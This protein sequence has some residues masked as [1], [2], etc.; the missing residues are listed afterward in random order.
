M[1]LRK[2]SL[3]YSFS[4][5]VAGAAI[6]SVLALFTTFSFLL[7][8]Q[9][10][11][12][13]V[14]KAVS[15]GYVIDAYVSNEI[16]RLGLLGATLKQNHHILNALRAARAVGG[17]PASASTTALK[18]ALGDI[19]DT[20]DVSTLTISNAAGESLFQFGEA[21]STVVDEMGGLAAVT[22]DRT[23]VEKVGGANAMI[24]TVTVLENGVRIGRITLGVKLDDRFAARIANDTFAAVTLVSQ[25]GSIATSVQAGLDFEKI[26]QHVGEAQRTRQTVQVHD[27]DTR[28]SQVF[29]ATQI[30]DQPYGVVVGVQSETALATLTRARAAA[31]WIAVAVLLLALI[32]GGGYVYRALRPLLTLQQRAEKVMSGHFGQALPEVPGDE[33]EQLVGQ[34]NW[35]IETLLAHAVELEHAKE[36]ALIASQAKSS[37]LASMS[38]EIRTPMN[39]VIGM[40][41]LLADTELDTQ[42]QDYVETIRSSG[43]SLLR[44]INDI[45][46]FSKIESGKMALE[47]HPFELA[48]CVEEV[49]G[50]VA[51]SAQKKK[52][53]L[54]YMVENDVPAWLN[55]DVTRVR[56]VLVNLIGNSVKFTDS[57]EVVVNIS[58]RE[59]EPGKL[60]I[61]FAIKD[62]GIGIP[63]EK[64]AV[65]FQPFYQVDASTSRKYGGSGLGLAI[66]ARLVKLMGG[67][68]SVSSEA[69]QGSTFSF[70][71]RANASEPVMIRYS[72][73]DQF[74]MQGKRVLIVDDNETG[75]HI[76]AAT[77]RRWGIDCDI[78]ALPARA[79]E[80]F[81]S[82]AHYDC[83]ILDFHMPGMDGVSLAREVRRIP[84]RKETP[85]VLFSSADVSL[86]SAG[87][88]KGLFVG[89][90]MKPLRQSQMFDIL[91]TTLVG[92]Q[93]PKEKRKALPDTAVRSNARVLLAEDNAINMQLAILV[94]DKLG[95]RTD[96]ANNGIEAVEATR[97]QRYDVILMDVQMPEMD[98]MEATREIRRTL[99]PGEQPFII[100]VT[101]NVM[102]ED[103]ALYAEAGMDAFV[104]KP[105]TRAE[106]GAVMEK[107]VR[108]KS[109]SPASNGSLVMA[110]AGEVPSARLLDTGRLGDIFTLLAGDDPEAF[111]RWITQLEA[112]L[113]HFETLLPMVDELAGRQKMVTALHALKG[114]C[115]LMAAQSLGE[116]FAELEGDLRRDDLAAFHERVVTGRTLKVASLNALREALARRSARAVVA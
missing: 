40:T 94:L 107:A 57:G 114:T 49:F 111:G 5:I 115:F 95:Y 13:D 55:G 104:P 26:R 75:L 7:D 110:V 4:L 70:S 10:R 53:D 43:T 48:V 47:E 11:A 87:V 58:R 32:A 56:Q 83:A 9:Y 2:K 63:V 89:Q 22:P 105:Y 37:F 78:A 84:H 54:L 29:L 71:L 24:H 44:I 76:L 31:I 42:Q 50:I 6:F 77:V 100:A 65:L 92:R 106:L 20:L 21:R 17:A 102:Q 113:L 19:I 68:I 14:E 3:V 73:S 99:P 108:A 38:H 93:T 80:R 60:E 88:D 79:L 64:Q 59:A 12:S 69:G 51:P 98:G 109:A 72:Q 41:S 86:D 15:I 116:F 97:R 85:L 18:V 45:L 96:T 52:I 33:V 35:M 16:R 66:C 36:A 27:G 112:A 46:D 67:D 1:N 82:D 62:T 8:R 90:L 39:G 81:L 91:V 25:D 101:A 23:T 61:L 34:F 28:T 74:A 30:V 103:Q